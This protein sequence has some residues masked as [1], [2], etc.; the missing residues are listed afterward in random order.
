PAL[1]APPQLLARERLAG[2]GAA[3]LGRDASVIVERRIRLLER[4]LQ[5]VT[6]E[7]IV[8]R[9][10]LFGAPVLRIDGPADRPDRA[11]LPFDPDHDAF[12]HAPIVDSL[13]HPLGEDGG[14]VT[15]TLPA[16]TLARAVPRIESWPG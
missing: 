4:V 12:H 1:E 10:R 7:E 14:P 11:G 5:F 8:V 9:V 16:R 2:R 6:L 15:P 13:E 3:V